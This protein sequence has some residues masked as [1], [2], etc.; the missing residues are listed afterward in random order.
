MASKKKP[1]TPKQP[2]MPPG[3]YGGHRDIAEILSA[4]YG[5]TVPNAGWDTVE[6][7]FDMDQLTEFLQEVNPEILE[8]TLK[9]QF[10]QGFL[11]GMLHQLVVIKNMQDDGE[12]GPGDGK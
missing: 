3:L 2:Q 9:D 10:L 4:A 5:S 1:R 12:E 7:L 8:H 6:E 11:M